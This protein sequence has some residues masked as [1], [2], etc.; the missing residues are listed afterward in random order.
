[1]IACRPMR[2]CLL[3]KKSEE[4]RVKAAAQVMPR[5]YKTLNEVWST[6]TNNTQLGEIH[7]RFLKFISDDM[8]LLEPPFAPVKKDDT[9]IKHYTK[10]EEGRIEDSIKQFKR[11]HYGD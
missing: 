10:E 11:K 2:V 8:K 4:M 9:C 7:L 1:M 5:Y 6:P 3:L